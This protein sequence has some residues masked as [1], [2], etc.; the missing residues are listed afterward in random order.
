MESTEQEISSLFEWARIEISKIN[1]QSHGAK[2]QIIQ[3]L[4]K[5]LEGKI[6]TESIAMEIVIQLRG[7]V[8]ERLIH[9]CLEEKYKQP[10]RVKNAR[11]R[12]NDKNLAAKALLNHRT[13][14]K[15]VLIDTQGNQIVS[16]DTINNT[17]DDSAFASNSSINDYNYD[18]TKAEITHQ[19]AI[20]EDVNT[21][22]HYRELSLKYKKLKEDLKKAADDRQIESNEKDNK[23]S[24]LELEHKQLNQD[25]K[26]KVAENIDLQKQIDYLHKQ[27]E[28]LANNRTNIDNLVSPKDEVIDFEYSM[29]WEQL[30]RYLNFIYKSGRPLR[31]WFNGRINKQTGRIIAAYPGRISEQNKIAN[32]SETTT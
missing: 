24:K 26:D 32:E 6:L 17:A 21:K 13:Q 28:N 5:K 20:D 29:P 14:N 2:K 12:A 4:A 7:S 31:I 22:D 11:K 3:D 16:K 30:H 19:K 27:L 23:I 8:S 25:I 18:H 9:E 15:K 1:L 10:H